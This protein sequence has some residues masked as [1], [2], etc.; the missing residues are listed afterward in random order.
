MGF[1]MM[2]RA[3]VAAL[4]LALFHSQVRADEPK[5]LAIDELQGTWLFNSASRGRGNDALPMVWKSRVIVKDKSIVVENFLDLMKPLK[6]TIEL[7][8]AGKIGHI[9]LRLEELDLKEIGPLKIPAGTL[10]GVYRRTGDK[11]ELCFQ[12]EPGGA[13][14]KSADDPGLKMIG[15]TLVKVPT[16][17]KDFPAAY[18][19]TV[20]TPDGKP[21]AGVSI[22]TFLSK[23]RDGKSKEGEEKWS[24]YKPKKTDQQGQL[25]IDYADEGFGGRCILAWDEANKLLG[26]G[27]ISPSAAV[28]K[29]ELAIELQ[30]T[31]S[32]YLNVTCDEL[33]ASG[34]TDYFNCYATTKAGQRFAL[35]ANKTG[36]LEFLLPGG[37]YKFNIY[38]T[39]YLGKKDVDLTVP[40]GQ[41]EFNS[42]EIKVPPSGLL[43]ILGKP[44]PALTDVVGWKGKE[45][46]LA[47]L[48]GQ[49]VL[50][51]FWGYWCGPCIGAMPELMELHE[52][53]AA[54]GLVI[55]GIHVDGDGEVDTAEKLEA[56]IAGYKKEVWKGKDL[57]F[58]SAITSGKRDDE[59]GFRSGPAAAY[60][61]RSFP[62]TILIDREGK[63]VGKFNARDAKSAIEQ[64]EK[65]L[66]DEKK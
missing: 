53:F 59:T 50:L 52:K 13:R 45:V 40:K 6:G 32:V 36:R 16:D 33:K 63:V 55:L 54:K 64:M 46:K 66:K 9:D 17:F 27:S 19:V 60:G 3:A 37:D 48:K 22:G 18:T 42:P 35:T 2:T 4:V 65:L 26:I 8:P 62:S 15:M 5:K 23:V 28:S 12:S 44:A 43:A 34:Q 30:P 20:T 39:E 49:V 58:P 1:D 56:K 25:K 61:I 11:V 41:S 38:G 29:P 10:A 57:P 24:M 21:A 47:D 31:C 7:D 51:E 14:P